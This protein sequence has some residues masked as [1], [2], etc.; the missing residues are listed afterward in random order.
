MRFYLYRFHKFD[1]SLINLGEILIKEVEFSM[2]KL[3][4][5]FLSILYFVIFFALLKY[6]YNAFVPFNSLT[7]ILA[8]FSLLSSL[9]P[10][11]SFQ[12]IKLSM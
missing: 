12:Q 4:F 2:E 7:D 1:S 3:V 8:V 9:S 5:F 10:H 6:V 11:K